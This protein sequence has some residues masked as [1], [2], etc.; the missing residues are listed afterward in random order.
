MINANRLTSLRNQMKRHPLDALV[1]T[2]PYYIAAL[3]DGAQLFNG[4]RAEPPGRVAII[5]TAKQIIVLGNRT[6]AERIASDELCG[7]S[8][9]E[10]IKY[11]WHQWKLLEAT[12]SLLKERNL[13]NCWA[14]S[15]GNY[16][17][18]CC[19]LLESMLYPLSKTEIDRLK[20]LGKL[21]AQILEAC[22]KLIN[23]DVTETEICAEIHKALL[24]KSALPDLIFVA[25]DERIEKYRHCKPSDAKLKQVAMISI[26]AS[27]RGL[28]ASASRLISLGQPLSKLVEDTRNANTIEVVAI[29]AVRSGANFNEI[30]SAMSKC[31]DELGNQDGWQ[32]HHLGGSSG[33]RG[34]DTKV[35]PGASK[36]VIPP[37]QPFVFNPV[38][39]MGKSE[40][41]F[42][43]PPD[44][45]K[46]E[47]L[48]VDK[49]WP[50]NDIKGHFRPGVLAK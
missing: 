46:L 36:L 22:V 30:F 37:G 3:F 49:C 19:N 11:P 29:E 27:Y 42:I 32:E 45:G 17:R 39:G 4:T 23:T 48:T 47:C 34:R 24:S 18:E 35:A 6:E 44:T 41:T 40:D 25:F 21:I 31:Y 13:K 26:T 43:I 2:E 7:F 38:F 5:V 12:K 15:F 50:K 28:Y 8:D 9:V 33:F 1:L 20:D 14:D 16:Q 10:C